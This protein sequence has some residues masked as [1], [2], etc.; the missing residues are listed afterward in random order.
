MLLHVKSTYITLL[1]NLFT[2]QICVSDKLF[3]N[4]RYRLASQDVAKFIALSFH[5]ICFEVEKAKDSL[6][7]ILTLIIRCPNLSA[8]TDRLITSTFSGFHFCRTL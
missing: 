1:Y 2:L 4:C 5:K 3:P 7:D 8:T 6:P